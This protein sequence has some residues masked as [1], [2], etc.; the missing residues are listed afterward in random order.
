MN[1]LEGPVVGGQE[2]LVEKSMSSYHES[3]FLTWGQKILLAAIS[4]PVIG[5]AVW[6]IWLQSW[7]TQKVQ[8]ILNQKRAAYSCEEVLKSTGSRVV[9]IIKG[10]KSEPTPLIIFWKEITS[11]P[12]PNNDKVIV[13]KNG[14]I[15]IETT[16]WEL[17]KLNAWCGTTAWLKY[18]PFWD[19]K[20]RDDIDVCIDN[21]IRKKRLKDHDTWKQ[22][23]EQVSLP[24]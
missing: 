14:L 23:T 8:E 6:V 20:I 18:K 9:C 2:V 15:T 1:A 24:I 10:G 21:E 17:A 7:H 16:R 5:W 3:P 11:I 19:N 13:I 12:Q 4:I 22:D